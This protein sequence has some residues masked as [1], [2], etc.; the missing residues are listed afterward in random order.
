MRAIGARTW[1]TIGRLL[2][3]CIA[4]N[5]DAIIFLSDHE[6]QI[7][8]TAMH[9]SRFPYHSLYFGVQLLLLPHASDFFPCSTTELLIH[10]LSVLTLQFLSR[11]QHLWQ[12]FQP[13]M[14][15]PQISMNHNKQALLLFWY[16]VSIDCPEIVAYITD[17]PTITKNIAFNYIL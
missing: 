7:T 11:F 8:I 4:P 12:M 6:K 17:N 13:K 9:H 5:H 2:Y 15:D 14:T 1:P 3:Y 10:V 16:N